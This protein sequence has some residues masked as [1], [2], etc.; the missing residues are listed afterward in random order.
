MSPGGKLICPW[1]LAGGKH[2]I[3]WV[4]AAFGDRGATEYFRC[5]T[6]PRALRLKDG[7]I[8]SDPGARVVIRMEA[9]REVRPRRR[10]N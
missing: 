4:A 5:I 10:R 7:V 9:R 2:E 1:E 8:E 6:C 3:V